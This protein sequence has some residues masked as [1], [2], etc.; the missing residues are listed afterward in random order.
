MERSLKTLRYQLWVHESV[1]FV[2]CK[3]SISMRL[4]V[5][6]VELRSEIP[7]QQYRHTVFGT[8]KHTLIYTAYNRTAGTYIKK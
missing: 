4:G 3:P 6:R 7:M 1:F 8:A 5:N 2:Q